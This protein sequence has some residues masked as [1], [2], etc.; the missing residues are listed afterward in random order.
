MFG[1]TRA[2]DRVPPRSR[3]P[4]SC[5]LLVIVPPN[6]EQKCLNWAPLFG[7]AQIYYMYF[8]R[9]GFRNSCTHNLSV[10]THAPV[11]TGAGPVGSNQ[12]QGVNNV[13]RNNLNC[14]TTHVRSHVDTNQTS[15]DD[16]ENFRHKVRQGT[17]KG[18]TE[19]RRVIMNGGPGGRRV[20]R[21]RA[22]L[23]AR[24]VGAAFRW[25]AW[26]HHA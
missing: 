12:R 23:S 1:I 16:M 8:E 4:Q 13:T 20:V 9:K 18:T 14:T 10:H 11:H 15:T 17:V 19:A 3:P 21:G 7:L 22:H 2:Q 26:R 25:R 5:T 6:R 24:L